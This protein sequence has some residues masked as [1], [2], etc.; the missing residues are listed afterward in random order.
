MAEA[1]EESGGD[2]AERMLDAL[3][4][5]EDAGGDIRGKQSA[6]ILVM[7]GYRDTPNYEARKYDLRVDD[8]IEPLKEMRRLL[9]T[10]RAYRH[11]DIGDSYLAKSDIPRALQFY[12]AAM[13]IAPDNHEMV[14][15]TAVT[16]ADTGA[17]EQSQPLFSQAFAAWPKWRELVPRLPDSGLLPDD[18]ALIAQILAIQ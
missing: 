10:A 5:A 12:E 4:A 11:M 17:I 1:F 16:L 6:A 15:W 14:F 13:A 2:L 3:D 9:T 7:A 8:S 18:E